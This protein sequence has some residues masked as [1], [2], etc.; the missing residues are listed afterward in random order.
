MFMVSKIHSKRE[1]QKRRRC[2]ISF[3]SA[4]QYLSACVSGQN[5]RRARVKLSADPFLLR[6]LYLS[7]LLLPPLFSVPPPLC[8]SPVHSLSDVSHSVMH[9]Q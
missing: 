3:A 9:S 8:L 2:T 4:V 1:I 5:K 7:L 6:S